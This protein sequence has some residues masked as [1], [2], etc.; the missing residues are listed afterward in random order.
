MAE[1]KVDKNENKDSEDIID[2]A[3]DLKDKREE[4]EKE[5]QEALGE[6]RKLDKA[7]RT[8]LAM[9]RIVVAMAVI[10][11]LVVLIVGKFNA[12]KTQTQNMTFEYNNFTFTKAGPLYYTQYQSAGQ[13]STIQF[14]YLPQDVINITSR[15]VFTEF[16]EPIYIS[17]Q[18]NATGHNLAYMNAAIADLS[19]KLVGIYGNVPEPACT[20]PYDESCKNVSTVTC[21]SNKSAVVFYQS[22]FS[23]I[24]FKGSC[25]EVY[26][27]GEDIYRAETKLVYLLLGI[28]KPN[29]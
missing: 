1:N 25:V 6:R 14:H 26:G 28:I 21:D 9:I 23:G 7:K 11:L 29:Q 17:F 4:L 5:E 18:P 2:K 3:K 20:F 15:G 8:D 27:S 12:S 13:L 10:A 19:R 16:K 24:I 22:N